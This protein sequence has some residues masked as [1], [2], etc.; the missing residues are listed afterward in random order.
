MPSEVS[1]ATSQIKKGK[2][3]D[4]KQDKQVSNKKGKNG[5][6]KDK[7]RSSASSNSSEVNFLQSFDLSFLDVLFCITGCACNGLHE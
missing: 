6:E 4:S 3:L 7:S 5:T 1:S 2:Q